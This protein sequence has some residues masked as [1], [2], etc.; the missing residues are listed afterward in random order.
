MR[1]EGRPL[2]EL[3]QHWSKPCWGFYIPET[4]LA[5]SQRVP[6]RP[7]GPNIGEALCRGELVTGQG[8]Y[9][10]GNPKLQNSKGLPVSGV[11]C[12]HPGAH[13][14]LSCKTFAFCPPFSSTFPLIHDYS[15]IPLWDH[16]IW[17]RRKLTYNFLLYH[18]STCMLPPLPT[19]YW[20]LLNFALFPI[21][22]HLGKSS[23]LHL[24]LPLCLHP[25]RVLWWYGEVLVI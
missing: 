9:L 8:F 12:P 25:K 11:F 21:A 5:Y 3:R 10:R 4:H 15:S 1:V 7:N 24:C 6:A 16:T 23:W 20:F 19:H 22:W 18:Y 17:K 13:K 2:S 14:A